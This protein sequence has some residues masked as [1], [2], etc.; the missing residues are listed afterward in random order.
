MKKWINCFG[1]YRNFLLIFRKP[2]D[3]LLV[4]LVAKSNEKFFVY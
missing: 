1:F 2:D 4:I 3:D